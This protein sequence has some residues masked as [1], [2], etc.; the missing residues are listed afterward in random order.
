MTDQAIS[1]TCKEN[2]CSEKVIYEQIVVK[3][4]TQKREASTP[5]IVYLS[6]SKGHIH[7]YEVPR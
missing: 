5:K 6:C 1:L 7:P 2:G 4:F 3:A